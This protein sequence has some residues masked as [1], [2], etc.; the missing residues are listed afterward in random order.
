MKLSEFPEEINKFSL[1]L[2]KSIEERDNLLVNKKAFDIEIE[3][4]VQGL[5][6]KICKN[7][8]QRDIARFDFRSDLYLELLAAIVEV[9]SEIAA[10]KIH[11]QFLRDAF[12]VAKLE[13]QDQIS[14]H[15]KGGLE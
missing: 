12:S 5:D 11:I 10:L 2:Q 3:K 4:R 1:E 8:S 9:D 15:Y 14:T 13:L 7:E 6:P